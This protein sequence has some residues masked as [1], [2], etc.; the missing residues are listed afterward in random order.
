MPDA[1]SF[2]QYDDETDV[3][4]SDASSDITTQTVLQPSTS[5]Q[6]GSVLRSPSVSFRLDSE[7]QINERFSGST[8]G[9]SSPS[10]Y[11]EVSSEP[12]QTSERTTFGDCTRAIENR[13]VDAENY[14]TRPGDLKVGV[15][16]Q[17]NE[18]DD[19]MT[20]IELM[21]QELTMLKNQLVRAR[22][23]YSYFLC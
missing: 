13:I 22:K 6:K 12:Y 4:Y 17:K 8:T 23:S 10:V 2:R 19:T 15:K 7:R 21:R 16:L 14:M 9:N 20:T 3:S 1:E 18:A 5:A 11:S